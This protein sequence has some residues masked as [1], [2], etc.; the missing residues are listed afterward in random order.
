MDFLQLLSSLFSCPLFVP[1]PLGVEAASVGCQRPKL[2]PV[3]EERQYVGCAYLQDG[4]RQ[5]DR[6]KRLVEFLVISID[7]G[8]EEEVDVCRQKLVV[9]VLQQK[10]GL[11]IF[12][13]P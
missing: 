1:V 4:N 2:V 13:K 6:V 7:V 10:R 8:I 3:D 9:D 12:Q 11:F 5:G